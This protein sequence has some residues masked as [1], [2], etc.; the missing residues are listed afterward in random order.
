MSLANSRSAVAATGGSPSLFSPPVGMSGSADIRILSALDGG[1]RA[2]REPRRVRRALIAVAMGIAC[3]GLLSIVWGH[4]V[5]DSASR[6]VPLADAGNREG[7]AVDTAQGE[8]GAKAAVQGQAIISSPADSSPFT[9]HEALSPDDVAL[10]TVELQRQAEGGDRAAVIID[11][12]AVSATPRSTPAVAARKVQ[13]RKSPSKVVAER[14]KAAARP[15]VKASASRVT[16][17]R[18]VRLTNTAQIAD[19]ID[20]D[21]QIIEA[22]VTR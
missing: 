8:G 21:V 1:S 7:R 17:K 20:P 10:K 6:P 2:T 4:R 3:I 16:P 11:A 5:R 14:R 19:P 12:V 22:I 9:R 18:A 13:G 15:V